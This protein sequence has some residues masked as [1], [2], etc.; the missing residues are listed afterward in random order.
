MNNRKTP[1]AICHAGRDKL[2]S[3]EQQ[4]ELTFSYNFNQRKKKKKIK[5][6]QRMKRNET[7]RNNPFANQKLTKTEKKNK[8]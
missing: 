3:S 5:S 7:K 1:V 2:N 4:K 8:N 6:R